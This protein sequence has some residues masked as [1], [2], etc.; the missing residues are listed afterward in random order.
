MKLTLVHSIDAK[1]YT[2]KHTSDNLLLEHLMISR[3]VFCLGYIHEGR[4]DEVKFLCEAH[5][6]ELV[7]E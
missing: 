6:W 7:I 2:G 1:A 3:S 5:N 4:L